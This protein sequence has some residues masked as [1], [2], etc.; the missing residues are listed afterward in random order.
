M[1][2]IIDFKLV[3]SFI[4][5]VFIFCKFE[6]VNAQSGLAFSQVILVGSTADT[7]PAGKVWKI[8]TIWSFNSGVVNSNCSSVASAID[9]ARAINI[10]SVTLYPVSATQT[11]SSGNI[12]SSGEAAS[13][14]YWIPAGTSVQAYCSG[15]QISVVEFTILP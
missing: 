10:N 14:P 4:I 13:F 8:E 12:F 9:Y 1:K 2:N 3:I 11:G 7:V 15:S 6:K 5:F